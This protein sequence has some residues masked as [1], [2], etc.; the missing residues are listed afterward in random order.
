[1]TRQPARPTHV[2]LVVF[3]LLVVTNARGETAREILDRRSQL[4]D[5]TRHWNDREQHVRLAIEKKG[6]AA[7]QRTLTIYERRLPHDEDQA[8][9]FF[10][11]P[12]TI[13]GVGFLSFS[14]PGRPDEQW[15]YLPALKRVRQIASSKSARSESFVGTDLTFHDLD[16]LQD[17]TSWSEAEAPA[18]LL[19]EAAVGGVASYQIEIRPARPD[20]YYPRIVMWL[21]KDDLV[22]RRTEFFD[23]AGVALK[24]IEQSDVR[25]VDGIP[26]PY[27][28]EARTLAAGSR[29]IMDVESV[30]FNTELPDD[31]FTQRSLMRGRR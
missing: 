25:P 28:T 16:V 24:R 1:M 30:R 27:R 21:G 11:E 29:T 17:M 31:V 14:H 12:A 22:M 5:T 9:L 3:A 15:L 2:A 19:G 23:A 6:G 20:V 13:K 8:L 18:T 26:I 7:Q 10:E 4:D